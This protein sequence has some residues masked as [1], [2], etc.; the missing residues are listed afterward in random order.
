MRDYEA[1]DLGSGL[2]E[3]WETMPL[4]VISRLRIF[5]HFMGN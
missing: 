4:F 5:M 2:D 3:R 1:G